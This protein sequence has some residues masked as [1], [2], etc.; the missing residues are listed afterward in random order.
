MMTLSTMKKVVETVNAEWRSPLAESILERW[1]YDPGS[2]YYFR[3]SANFLFIF[4]RNEKTYFLRFS[5]A[6]EK[7]LT[8]IGTEVRI[9]NYL[10]EQTVKV[11]LPVKSLNGCEIETVETDI[12]TFHAVVFEALPGKQFETEELEMGQF[13][14]WGNALGRLHHVFK[15]MPSDISEPRASWMTQLQDIKALLP[16]TEI[17]ALQELDE[18]MELGKSL[19][20]SDENFGLIHFDYE[21]DN[22]R[23]DE[24][25]IG[26]LDFDDCIKSLVC[27]R[28]RFCIKGSL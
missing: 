8:S 2:V 15:N 20:V 13:F 22:L 3:A 1:G 24:D 17:A 7:D 6:T 11:A 10:R 18:I 28:H 27:G 23:W 25:T 16:K 14:R 26:M 12:G 19:P 4:K 21:L 9:L 5:D